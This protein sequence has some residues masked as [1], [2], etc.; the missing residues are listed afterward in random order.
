MRNNLPLPQRLALLNDVVY[1]AQ[2]DGEQTEHE[3]EMVEILASAW[4]VSVRSEDP[5][6]SEA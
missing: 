2:C 6:E 3:R 1:I 4:K 5:S